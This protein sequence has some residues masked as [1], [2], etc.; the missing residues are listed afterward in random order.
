[1]ATSRPAGMPVVCRDHGAAYHGLQEW[2][3]DMSQLQTEARQMPL[4][5]VVTSL[6]V[7]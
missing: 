4:V 7:K 6:T 2:P 5:Q 1:M 3:H